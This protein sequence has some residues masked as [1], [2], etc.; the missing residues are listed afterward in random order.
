MASN[1][2]NPFVLFGPA[3]ALTLLL[4]VLVGVALPLAVRRVAAGGVERAVAA[5]LAVALLGHVVFNMWVRVQWYGL[6]LVQHLP[7]HL[8]G[9]AVLLVAWVLARRSYSAFEVA[10][11]W[12]TGGTVQAILT[13]DLQQ[14]FPS[15]LYV[16]FFVGH[17]LVIVGVVYAIVVYG[18][19]PTLRS[20]VKTAAVTLACMAV[21]APLNVVLGTNYL[22]L[23]HKPEGASLIDYLGPWPWYIAALVA[24]GVLSCLVYYAPFALLAWWSRT[25][26]AG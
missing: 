23:R 12:A 10:Y 1:G 22:Y 2:E 4:V 16:N 18:F 15:P 3:H 8:C 19:R 5:G 20:V 17:G 21:I 24:V 14:G 6:P 26:Q 9:L 25:R 11:F 13:P 7:L